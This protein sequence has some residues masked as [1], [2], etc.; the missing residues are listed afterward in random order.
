ME[1]SDTECSAFRAAAGLSARISDDG[2]ISSVRLLPRGPK[3]SKGDSPQ[4]GNPYVG[5]VL[6]MTDF[7][8]NGRAAIQP[9]SLPDTG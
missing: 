9:N 2:I 8:G 7:C 1:T 5:Q 4:I 6:K 3:W